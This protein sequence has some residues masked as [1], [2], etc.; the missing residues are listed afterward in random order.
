MSVLAVCLSAIYV[1]CFSHMS[2]FVVNKRIYLRTIKVIAVLISQK[3]RGVYVK[4]C[5]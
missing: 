1:W 3:P 4:H 2:S 5:K